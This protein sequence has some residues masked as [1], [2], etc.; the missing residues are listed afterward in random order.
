M[1]QPL[2]PTLKLKLFLEGSSEWLNQGPVLKDSA[3]VPADLATLSSLRPY[4]AEEITAGQPQ[5]A[6]AQRWNS[7][8]MVSR[9]GL[10]T[11]G[12]A[13]INAKVIL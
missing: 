1:A 8:S 7:M 13:T 9:H 4:A 6:P 11:N 12:A 5:R 2:E 3:E 10:L